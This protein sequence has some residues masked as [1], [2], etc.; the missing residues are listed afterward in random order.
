MTHHHAAINRVAVAFQLNEALKAIHWTQ[1]ALRS[2]D[3][4]L[5]LWVDFADILNHLCLAWHRKRW[6]PEEV[7]KQSQDDYELQAD[8][9]PNWGGRFQLVDWVVSL[10]TVDLRVSRGTINPETVATYLT[11]AEAALQNLIRDIATDQ[12]DHYDTSVLETQC[13]LI[14]R[15]LC[16]AWHLRHLTSVEISLLEPKV[17]QQLEGWVP[18]WDPTFRLV[19]RDEEVPAGSQVEHENACRDDK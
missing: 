8:S 15:K 11:V 2:E 14:L 6:G 17:L 5:A 4:D 9:I 18:P 13:E 12:S 3:P 19:S 1:S 7:M 16:L 10:P